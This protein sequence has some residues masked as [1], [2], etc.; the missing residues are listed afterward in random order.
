MSTHSNTQ[1]VDDILG[2]GSTDDIILQQKSAFSNTQKINNSLSGLND[3][4]N[5]GGKT[6]MPMQ[7]GGQHSSQ[8]ASLGSRRE[9]NEKQP[10][11]SGQQLTR[12]GTAPQQLNAML[13]QS[14]QEK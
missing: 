13:G 14:N 2:N 12:P 9:L 3:N 1:Q 5:D 4:P 10:L 7:R 6:D 8:K 11:V